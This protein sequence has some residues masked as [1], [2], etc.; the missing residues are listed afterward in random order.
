M[1]AQR[2]AKLQRRRLERL[3]L[4]AYLVGPQRVRRAGFGRTL[5]PFLEPFVQSTVDAV[6]CS[7]LGTS[8]HGRGRNAFVARV[9]RVPCR[10]AA[11]VQRGQRPSATR[12]FARSGRA[13][14]SHTGAEPSIRSKG[15]RGRWKDNRFRLD[16]K[17]GSS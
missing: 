5:R 7:S 13:W 4:E 3:T 14:T 11:E 12:A 10:G 1:P 9:N 17:T 6:P 16:I 8:E 2:V 15:H